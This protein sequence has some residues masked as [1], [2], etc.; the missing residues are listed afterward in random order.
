MVG[1]HFVDDFCRLHTYH[2]CWL[3]SGNFSCTLLLAFPPSVVCWLELNTVICGFLEGEPWWSGGGG[4]PHSK[5]REVG[6][7]DRALI[8][9]WVRVWGESWLL[10]QALPEAVFLKQKG[11]F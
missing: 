9:Q 5:S 7:P 6:V 10:I 4:R 2:Y 3:F 11:A 1:V 8:E